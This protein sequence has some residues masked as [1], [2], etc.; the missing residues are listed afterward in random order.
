LHTSSLFWR[1]AH[2]CLTHVIRRE[3]VQLGEERPTHKARRCVWPS[4]FTFPKRF[5]VSR[6]HCQNRIFQKR[7]AQLVRSAFGTHFAK[8]RKKKKLP[9]VEWHRN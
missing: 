8:L 7:E 2:K 5:K 1:D 3:R 4:S 9:C 6:E